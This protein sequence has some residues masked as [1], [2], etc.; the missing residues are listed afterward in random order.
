MLYICCPG[1]PVAGLVAT[2]VTTAAA[3]VKL[4]IAERFIVDSASFNAF[5]FTGA[6]VANAFAN[7]PKLTVDTVCNAVFN[8]VR[9]T[10]AMFDNAFANPPKLTVDTVDN[11]LTNVDKSTVDTFSVF[12]IS[13]ADIVVLP[14]PVTVAQLGI[15]PS[16]VKNLPA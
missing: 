4:D 7:P 16:V 11:A 8:A 3:F 1:N 6:K 5:K 13:P 14:P 15:V 10:G 9:F 12:T 2:V